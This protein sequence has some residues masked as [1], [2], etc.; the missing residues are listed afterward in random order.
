AEW[1]K[2]VLQSPDYKSAPYKVVICHMPPFGGW[3]GEKE[4]ANKF[5]RLL[6]EAGAQVMLSGHLHRHMKVAP[7]AD[8]HK[9]P[10]LVNSNNN[11]LRAKADDNRLLIEVVDQQ[12][13]VVDSLELKPSK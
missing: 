12:G 8:N 13:K 2:E 5:V 1:L 7:T 3:H 11:L 4:I 9:F 6:N 10:L